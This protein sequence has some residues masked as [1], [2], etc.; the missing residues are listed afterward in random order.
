VLCGHGLSLP[1]VSFFWSPLPIV[2][3]ESDR[4]AS[5]GRESVRRPLG[6]RS[7]RLEICKSLFIYFP[8]AAHWLT[9][10]QYF[11]YCEWLCFELVFV[12]LFIVETRGKS[13]EDIAILFDGEWKPDH[14]PQLVY[15]NTAIHMD[16]SPTREIF[17]TGAC[18]E[19]A[20]EAWELKMPHRVVSKDRLGHDKGRVRVL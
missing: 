15:N 6:L 9:E 17:F 13:P 8:L 12:M 7:N 1:P 11:V 10:F 5:T 14:L 20:A 3:K 19:R 2:S 18:K 16:N 4:L